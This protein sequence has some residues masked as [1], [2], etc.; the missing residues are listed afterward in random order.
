M[1]V[2]Q[3]NTKWAGFKEEN[4]SGC[5]EEIRKKI[6]IA[7]TTAAGEARQEHYNKHQEEDF[8]HL[9]ILHIDLRRNVDCAWAEQIEA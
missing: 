5:S 7:H 2:D 4:K 8:D 9:G 3:Q 1:V 6:E